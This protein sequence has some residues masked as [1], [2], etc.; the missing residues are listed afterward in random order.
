MAA[1][2]DIDRI[3]ALDWPQLLELWKRIALGKVPE[4]ASGKAMEHLVL[5]AFELDGAEV[6]WPYSVRLQGNEV[7]QIDGVV[8]CAGL[9]CLVESKDT[10]DRVNITPITKLRYQLLRRPPGVLGLVFSRSGFTEPALILAQFM[11]P[12]NILLYE[13][14]EVEHLLTQKSMVGPLLEKYRRCVEQ[15][16]PNYDTRIGAII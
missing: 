10:T 15:A 8:H 9:S 3:R 5:R 14:E 2:N 1:T 4:C 6:V 16:L 11:S 13:G 7:E 12:L